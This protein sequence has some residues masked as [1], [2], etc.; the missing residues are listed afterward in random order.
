MKGIIQIELEHK[1]DVIRKKKTNSSRSLK[2]LHYTI[3][4]SPKLEKNTFLSS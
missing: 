3:I 1:T 4:E 2:D